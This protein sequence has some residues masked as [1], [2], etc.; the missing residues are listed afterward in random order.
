MN[1]QGLDIL[2]DEQLAR[3]IQGFRRAFIHAKYH[4]YLGGRGRTLESS[5]RWI[6]GEHRRLSIL[7]TEQIVRERYA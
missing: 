6:W 7:V 2:S 5:N 3:M 1:Y 4:R